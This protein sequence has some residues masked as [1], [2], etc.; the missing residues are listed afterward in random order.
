MRAVGQQSGVTAASGRGVRNLHSWAWRSRVNSP[1]KAVSVRWFAVHRS[2]Y[3]DH[4][5]V[6]TPVVGQARVGRRARC[7]RWYRAG[8]SCSTDFSTSYRKL[9]R[10]HFTQLDTSITT[11]PFRTPRTHLRLAPITRLRRSTPRLFPRP[12]QLQH[13]PCPASAPTPTPSC[14]LRLFRRGC[15]VR[16]PCPWA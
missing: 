12:L 3:T 11:R 14:G 2:R 7:S 1:S 9:R 13:P 8:V 4:G 16:A 10:L 15:G 6:L 5:T